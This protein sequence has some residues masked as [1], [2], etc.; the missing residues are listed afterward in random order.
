GHPRTICPS[1]YGV[2][3]TWSREG[4][5]VFSPAFYSGLERVDAAGGTPKPI[6]TI[7]KSRGETGHL[8]PMFLPHSRHL[9][10]ASR[11]IA[12]EPNRIETVSVDGGPRNVVVEAD[13]LVG[14]SDPWLLFVKGGVLFA[15]RFDPAAGTVSGDRRRLSDDAYYDENISSGRASVAG[16]TL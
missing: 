13:G 1:S 8:S 14:Y 16:D 7:D 12:G 11:A 3:G 2:G 6:T 10:F 5:I 15:Q 4:V 9:L